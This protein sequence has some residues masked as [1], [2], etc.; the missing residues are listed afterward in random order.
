MDTDCRVLNKQDRPIPGLYACGELTAGFFY[1]NYPSG[2]GLLRGAVTG[3][4]GGTNAAN[5]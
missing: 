1:Y 5:R 4:I 3:K 2:S